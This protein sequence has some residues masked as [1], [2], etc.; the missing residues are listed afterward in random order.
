MMKGYVVWGLAIG[1]LILIVIIG[2][3]ATRGMRSAAGVS[4]EIDLSSL[5]TLIEPY[6]TCSARIGEVSFSNCIVV[7][8]HR[9]GYLLRVWRIFGGGSRVILWD[10]IVSTT[11]QHNAFSK[12]TALELKDGESVRFYGYVAKRIWNDRQRHQAV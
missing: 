10:D 2:R 5:G 11:H 1:L 12:S 6:G 9:N 7:D 8:R 4:K 3:S